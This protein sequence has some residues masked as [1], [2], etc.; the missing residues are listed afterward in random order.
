MAFKGQRFNPAYLHQDRPQREGSRCISID[1]LHL[2]LFSLAREIIGL[3]DGN[4][5]L[6]DGTMLKKC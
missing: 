3:A 2:G 5:F 4:D 1:E 6:H